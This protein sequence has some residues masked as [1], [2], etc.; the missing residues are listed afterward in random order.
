MITILGSSG[1]IGSHLLDYLK[2]ENIDFF[3]PDRDYQ[4]KEKK[5]LGHVIYCI[6][7]TADFRKKPY[8]TVDAHV[9]KLL[10]VIICDRFESLLFLSSTR[11]Y[12]KNAQGSEESTLI[13][14]PSDFSDL[15][16]ISKLMGESL[17]LSS[18]K[19]NIR[20]VRLSNV[21][22]NDSQS[23]N[24]F[25][26]LIRE[27]VIKKSIELKAS[28]KDKKDYIH[29]NDVT[30]MIVAIALNGKEKLYNLASGKCISHDQITKEISNI[31]NCSV[32]FL[33][34]ESGL[35]FPEISIEKLEKE[36]NF[37]PASVLDEIPKLVKEIQKKIVYDPN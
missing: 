7:L 13:V 37:I 2:K 24:F 26:S 6:G 20:V 28:P 35:K 15:Y 22:G 16:N 11:V 10:E 9:C 19:K 36:F 12:S 4:F 21:I 1:F 27:A 34:T 30:R 14:N 5:N 33:N 8:E 23:D 31:L 29:I 17:C 32:N 18:K 3:A 25:T